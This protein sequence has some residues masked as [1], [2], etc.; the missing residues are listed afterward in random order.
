MRFPHPH[1]PRLGLEGSRA[2]GSARETDA[3]A[4]TQQWQKPASGGL[5]GCR[6]PGERHGPQ[7]LEAAPWG[8]PL[9]WA[10]QAGDAAGPAARRGAGGRAPPRGS[11]GRTGRAPT[12][13]APTRPHQHWGRCDGADPAKGGDE[14][15]PRRP[16]PRE[17]PQ[18]REG[19]VCGGV[20]WQQKPPSDFGGG[21][22]PVA[23]QQNPHRDDDD[24]PPPPRTRCRIHLVD[25]AV[26]ATADALDE[27]EVLLGVA[28]G[29]VAHPPAAAHGARAR[30]RSAAAPQAG[31]GVGEG[32]RHRSSH[33]LP[34]ARSGNMAPQPQLR[35]G[36]RYGTARYGAPP[37]SSA[38]ALA[39]ARAGTRRGGLSCACSR[40][41]AATRSAPRDVRRAGAAG[42]ARFPPPPLPGTLLR[43]A[44]SS[45]QPRP[46]AQG[47]RVRS[48]PPSAPPSA[49][50]SASAGS[51]PRPCL[52]PGA[53]GLLLA[54]TAGTTPTRGGTGGARKGGCRSAASPTPGCAGRSSPRTPGCGGPAA[55]WASTPASTASSAGGSGAAGSGTRRVQPLCVQPGTQKACPVP[56]HRDPSSPPPPAPGKTAPEH[57]AGTPQSQHGNRSPS[58]EPA[59][60]AGDPQID[61]PQCMQLGTPAAP[62]GPCHAAP[63]HRGPPPLSPGAQPLV[64]SLGHGTSVHGTPAL[65]A[66]VHKTGNPLGSQHC[67]VAHSANSCGS[68]WGPC[69]LLWGICPSPAGHGNHMLWM[70][71]HLHHAVHPPVPCTVGTASV[72][73]CPMNPGWA[74]SSPHLQD[75]F[76]L[77]CDFLECCAWP[78]MTKCAP[79]FLLHQRC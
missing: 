50:A 76:T 5:H 11:W 33:R 64:S 54:P 8:R 78:H 19:G 71:P 34:P 3:R 55:I 65:P 26:G 18:G 47:G 41:A 57:A 39:P 12:G 37:R 1:S 14:G 51:A 31:G 20:S 4:G 60:A 13:R 24:S 38:A 6:K 70:C 66:P 23:W 9:A 75:C 69:Q 28:P 16:R 72:H 7:A 40:R 46:P 43:P 67:P 62:R 30:P 77:F 35:A 22:G 63:V 79:P 17:T 58:P 15:R 32:T 10:G 68:S 59:Y 2:P 25:V 74:T 42:P 29:Q 73:T 45:S 48:A 53:P 52:S 21:T 36:A 49:S 44:P 61:R 27:L 56:V